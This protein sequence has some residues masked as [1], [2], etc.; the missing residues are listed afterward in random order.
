MSVLGA[1]EDAAK[2]EAIATDIGD[3]IDLDARA[4]ANPAEVVR[5]SQLVVVTTPARTLLLKRKGMHPGLQ[6]TSVRSD[7]EGKQEIDPTALSDT[8]LYVSDR[9]SQCSLL[10]ELSGTRDAGLF[11][12]TRQNLARWL[13]ARSGD[14]GRWMT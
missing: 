8:N 2:A 6:I 1:G 7:M 13:R 5:E 10:G 14:D 12:T 11:S 3:A 4:R 9:L